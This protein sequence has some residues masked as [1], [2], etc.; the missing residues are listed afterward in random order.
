MALNGTMVKIDTVTVG[1]GGAASIDF[2][3]IPQTYTD[4]KVVLSVRGSRASVDTEAYV[5]F[6][7]NTSNYSYRVL[8]GTGSTTGSTRASSYPPVVIKAANSTASTFSNGEIYIPNYTSS[9]NKSLCTDSVSETNATGAY[10]YLVAGLW[11]NTAAINQ[12][13]LTPFTDSFVQ[14][15]TATL[16]GISRTTAQIKATGGMVYDD[17]DYVYHLFAS[18]GTFTQTQALTVDYL[19][20]AGGGGGAGLGGAGGGAGGLRSTVSNTGGGGALESALSLTAGSGV[21][22]T[23][24]AG[25]AGGNTSTGLGTSGANSVFSTITSTGGGGAQHVTNG[26]SGGSGAGAGASGASVGTGTA[27]QGFSGGTTVDGIPGRSSGGGGGAGQAGANATSSQGGKGGD[28]VSVSI[29]GSALNYAGG[30]GGG[31]DAVTG[32]SGAGGLGG[33]GAAAAARTT[34]AGVAG[35]ANTGGGGGGTSGTVGVNVG[36]AGGAGGSGV[37]IVRYAK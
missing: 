6:N 33:G 32:S 4:L 17:A 16:Y 22:V 21:T 27:N 10:Q 7:N 2:T 14:H 12:I 8:F 13:T 3:S 23:V 1:S 25:G 11:S 24:G 18:S 5:K 26:L 34:N 37:V 29:T 19:V 20:V 28:G 30:G 31:F 9:V 15:S 36:G 35:T